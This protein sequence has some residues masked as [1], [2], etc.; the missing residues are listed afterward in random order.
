MFSTI[1]II[2]LVLILS[3]ALPSMAFADTTPRWVEKLGALPIQDGGRVM[4]LDT[5][6]RSLA[7]QLTGREKWPASSGPEAFAGKHPVEL[8]F[9][10]EFKGEAIVH[11]PLILIDTAAFKKNVGLDEKQRFFSCV[12]IGGTKGIESLLLAYKEAK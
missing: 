12:Q 4:P 10:L 2:L 1:L 8:L 11:K 5:Y 9:D 3:L 7:S 6:A